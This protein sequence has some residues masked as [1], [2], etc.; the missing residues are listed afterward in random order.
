MSKK[1]IE[2]KSI[3][4]RHDFHALKNYYMYKKNSQRTKIMA[5]IFVASLLMLII[6]E[7]EF[8]FPFF[9][10]V[11]LAGIIVIALIYS[12]IS[13]D[14]KPLDTNLRKIVNKKQEL[15]LR[16]DGFSI[17]WTGT[18][19][20]DYAWSDIEYAYENDHHFFVFIEKQFGFVIPKLLLKGNMA[21]EVHE[22]L[23][24]H[25][26]LINDSTGWKYQV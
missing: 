9:K 21:K 2:I 15:N 12:W 7:T 20:A 17:K 19:Q 8:G 18:E 3:M 25:V 10:L 16:D 22:L 24:T 6:S 23:D 5:Y 14:T 4:E 1:N 11:G 26:R 13:I